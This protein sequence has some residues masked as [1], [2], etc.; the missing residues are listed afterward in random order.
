MAN[1]KIVPQNERLLVEP[2]EVKNTTSSG[3]VIMAGGEDTIKTT[4][5]T[6]ISVA[7]SLKD[8][9]K[10]G[11]TVYYSDRA[12]VR[13]RLSNKNYVLLTKSEVLAKIEVDAKD[14][15]KEINAQDLA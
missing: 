11:E 6:I 5:A 4:F 1:L 9:Y 10:K 3:L 7:E 12:G 2:I 13:F 15:G 8:D 14:L